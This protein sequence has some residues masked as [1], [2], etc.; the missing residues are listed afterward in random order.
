MQND[1]NDENDNSIVCN[2]L[3]QRY[4][5]KI[6][7][8]SKANSVVDIDNNCITDKSSNLDSKTKNI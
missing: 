7:K 5:D 3:H 1:T 4:N 2:I 6:I 8:E